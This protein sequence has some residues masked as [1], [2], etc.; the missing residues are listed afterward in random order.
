MTT[1]SSAVSA[2]ENAFKAFARRH[3]LTGYFALAFALTWVL[4]I[5]IMF[6]QMGLGLFNLPEPLL[7]ILFL[8]STYSGPLPAALIMTSL[9]DGKEGRRQLWR[10]MIQWRVGLGWYLLVLVGYPLIFLVGLT[11][12]LGTA[13]WIGLSQNWPLIFTYYLPIAAVGIIFPSLGEEPGWRG[14]ALPRLQQ[15]YGPLV[16]TLILGV[17]HGLWH[18]PAYF[19]P[20]AILEGPFDITAFAAN[21]GL[22][23]A[24]TVIWTWLFNNAGQ[25]IFFAMFVHGVSNAT[26]GLIPQLV[27]DPSADPWA[28]FKIGAVVALLLILFTHRQLGYQPSTHMDVD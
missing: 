7:F 8:L 3:P 21:T 6:S 9:I 13:P 18:L 26:S 14:F 23:I 25:S 22:L 19:I 20:G 12:Y 4:L 28:S 17:L 27:A 2:Q 24:M 5:P 16:G 10:R 15:Q 11:F 1:I